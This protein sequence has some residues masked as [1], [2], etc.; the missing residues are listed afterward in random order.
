MVQ[1]PSPTIRKFLGVIWYDWGARMSGIFTVPFTIAAVIV[2]SGHGRALFGTMAIL[3]FIVTAYRIWADERW[4]L[5]DI[6]RHLAPRLRF[7]FDPREANFVSS[8]QTNGGF[9]MLY[10]RVLARAI[11][12]TVNNC[13]AYLQRILEWDGERYVV[14]FDEP[15]LLPWSHENP[16]SVQPKELNHGVDTFL[17]VAWFID[18]ADPGSGYSHSAF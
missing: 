12:P 1:H 15:L 3:A 18:S 11:S 2:P 13:R 8:I 6:E 14:L 7:E 16:L 4:K 5:I 17:D 10:V 9:Y